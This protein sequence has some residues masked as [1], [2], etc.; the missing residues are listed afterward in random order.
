M[1]KRGKQM[2]E[3][4][5]LIHER[6]DKYELPIFVADTSLEIAKKL[7]ISVN[8]V[9]KRLRDNNQ[10]QTKYIISRIEI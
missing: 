9:N 7:G 8:A 6:K 4:V 1:Y 5:F 3:V 2:K 10:K